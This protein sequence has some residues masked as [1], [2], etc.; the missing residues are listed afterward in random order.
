MGQNRIDDVR[1]QVS[2]GE[3]HLLGDLLRKF[4]IRGTP[5]WQ[6]AGY[7]LDTTAQNFGFSNGPLVSYLD[8]L[9]GRLVCSAERKETEPFISK[10]TWDGERFVNGDFAIEGLDKNVGDSLVACLVYGTGTRTA[11][12]NYSSCCV[13]AGG[14][15]EG[16]FA[17]PSTHSLATTFKY[18]VEPIDDRFEWLA[19]STEPGVAREAYEKAVDS[20]RR[21]SI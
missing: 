12:Q 1:V 4:A 17:V 2:V 19:I 14:S 10:F 16:F 18:K 5:T 20:L 9:R 13:A 3:G 21:I 8:L 11:E 15:G 6:I 7:R